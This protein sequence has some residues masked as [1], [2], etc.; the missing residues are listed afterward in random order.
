MNKIIKYFSLLIILSLGT[1]SCN[2][3]KSPVYELKSTPV[4]TPLENPMLVLNEASAGF[5]AE[6]FSWS[7]GDYGFSAAPLYVLQADNVP[8]FPDPINLAESTQNY[9]SVTVDKLNTAATILGAQPGIP[10]ETYIRLQARLTNNNVVYSSS[11]DLQVSTYPTVIIYPKLYVPGS[12]QG[13]DIANAPTLVSYRMNNKYEGFLN[14]T[15]ASNPNAPI[16]FKLTSQ[17]AWGQGNEYG[18]GGGPGTLALKGGDISISPQGYYLMNVDLNT[19][20]YTATQITEITVYGPSA[21]EE[22]EFIYNPATQSW[23]TTISLTQGNIS[24]RINRN[25]NF[26]YGDNN[27][28]GFLEKNSVVNIEENGIYK[29]NLFLE[30]VPC[31]YEFIKQ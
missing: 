14:L 19:L 22:T 3:D 31:R 26:N 9:V 5:I 13:W 12:Y 8:S 27:K 28:D 7:K 2:D 24:F 17:P 23:E 4:I 20:T 1:I 15:D 25:S 6:T 18:S 10:F 21:E 16:T 29:I 11:T 30:E